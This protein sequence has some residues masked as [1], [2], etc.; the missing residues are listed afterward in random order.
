MTRAIDKWTLTAGSALLLCS[1]AGCEKKDDPAPAAEASV[2]AAQA[3]AAASAAIAAGELRAAEAA[4]ASAAAAVPSAAPAASAEATP[5][6]G[7]V[8]RFADKEKA[9]TGTTKVVLDQ[10]KVFN[11]PDNTKPSVAALTKDLVVVRLATLDTGWTLVEFPSGV[12][13]VSPGWIETKSL[14][15]SAATPT[16]SASSAKAA[17]SAAPAASAKPVA[18]AAAS[19]TPTPAAST[20]A[21]V[22]VRVKPGGILRPPTR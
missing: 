18:S 6:L 16:A 1:L 9:V 2:A 11:E 4:A 17:S 21:A 22:K 8:K 12:G 14:V 7:D 10:S 19:T 3:I 13:K 5:V 15:A 20:S